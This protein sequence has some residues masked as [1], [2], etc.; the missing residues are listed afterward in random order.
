MPELLA[1]REVFD[2][3]RSHSFPLQSGRKLALFLAVFLIVIVLIC[4]VASLLLVVNHFMDFLPFKVDFPLRNIAIIAAISVIVTFVPGIAAYMSLPAR[5][6][7]MFELQRSVEEAGEPQ[8]KRKCIQVNKNLAIL[9]QQLKEWRDIGFMKKYADVFLTEVIEGNA[10]TYG[11]FDRA[12]IVFS[13]DVLEE[14][15]I[16][17]LCS[18]LAHECGHIEHSDYVISLLFDN[19][20]KM[21]NWLSFPFTLI[22][23]LLS[24][25]ARALGRIPFIGMILMTGIY[26]LSALVK[27]ASMPLWLPRF[28]LHWRGHLDEY[29]ADDY[30]AAIGN[31]ATGLIT[32]LLKL[33]EISLKAPKSKLARRYDLYSAVMLN[34]ETLEANT[35]VGEM[36]NVVQEI[37]NSSHPNLMLRCKR[38][39]RFGF[40]D[41][42]I[43]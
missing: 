41:A 24:F 37:E 18:I 21:F 36:L 17:Q 29:F 13:R 39:A 14:M 16:H 5:Q 33:S 19:I 2:L 31:S 12:R 15:H 40:L 35:T 38:L 20:T 28:L 43:S 6:D 42:R 27:I 1:R 30:A 10:F 11:H 8:Q 26:F 9:T 23:L 4:S 22:T 25:L 32:S 34:A 7:K 3:I